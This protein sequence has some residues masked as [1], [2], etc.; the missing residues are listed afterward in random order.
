MPQEREDVKPRS[1]LDREFA[2]DYNV[3]QWC[4]AGHNNGKRNKRR[5]SLRER[6]WWM[7]IAH[8]HDRDGGVAEAQQKFWID[9]R[10]KSCIIEYKED[11]VC[12]NNT[13]LV[14]FSSPQA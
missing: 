13:E 3:G 2:C 1:A 7:T 4:E 14:L 10:S 8:G 6:R 9:P 11:R 5:A 12:G